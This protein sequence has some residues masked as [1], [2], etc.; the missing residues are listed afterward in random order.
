MPFGVRTWIARSL[1]VATDDR[2]EPQVRALEL[3]AQR[4]DD[5]PRLQRAAG[6]AGQQRRVEHEVDVVDER[7][8]RALCG[9]SDRSSVRAA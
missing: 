8:P 7:D 3:L 2:A 9:G 1:G 4:H 5:V 6:G